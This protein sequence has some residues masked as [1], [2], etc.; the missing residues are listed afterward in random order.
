MH[1]Y[2][3]AVCFL[4]ILLYCVHFSQIRGL[5]FV[6][7]QLKTRNLAFFSFF[8]LTFSS[9]YI[10]ILATALFLSRGHFY[11]RSSY[12]RRRHVGKR[13]TSKCSFRP[14]LPSFAATT[15]E[16]DRSGKDG[17]V[18]PSFSEYAKR[19]KSIQGGLGYE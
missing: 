3:I 5:F 7:L 10:I 4:Y 17:L 1:N 9:T 16:E 6:I 11:S 15:G 18:L 12:R 2:S 19:L 8:G 13:K 14:S